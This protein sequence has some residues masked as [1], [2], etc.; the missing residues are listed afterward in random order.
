MQKDTRQ[1]KKPVTLYY[2]CDLKNVS[3]ALMPPLS[4]SLFPGC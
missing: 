4:L 3:R 2:F 1:K